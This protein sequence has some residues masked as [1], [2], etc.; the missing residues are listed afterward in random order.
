METLSST[1]EWDCSPVALR[2][3]LRSVFITPSVT[4]AENVLFQNIGVN[5]AGGNVTL[6]GG[7]NSFTS[8]AFIGTLTNTTPMNT[9]AESN[10]SIQAPLG[11][12]SLTGL[13]FG[14]T[15]GGNHALISN[16][17]NTT[18]NAANYDVAINVGNL[19]L[20]GTAPGVM[21]T[22]FASIFSSRNLDVHCTH[23]SD[24]ILTAGQGYATI[25]ANGIMTFDIDGNV[26]LFGGSGFSLPTGQY[27]CAQIGNSTYTANA[28]GD[29]IFQN[30]GGTCTLNGGSVLNAFARIG[31]GNPSSSNNITG[32]I[33][34]NHVGGDLALNGGSDTT[35]SDYAQLGHYGADTS[36][37][38]FPT[39]TGDVFVNGVD[40]AIELVSGIIGH[41]GGAPGAEVTFNG[42]IQVQGNTLS[43]LG[44]GTAS[45]GVATVGNATIGFDLAQ[46]SLVTSQQILVSTLHGI[47]LSGADA[48]TG[49]P[50]VSGEA[51]IGLRGNVRATVGKLAV[52]STEGDIV[53]VAGVPATVNPGGNG[54]IGYYNL[55][56]SGN[57]NIVISELVFTRQRGISPL[58]AVPMIR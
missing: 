54:V 8:A 43:M 19:L 52:S 23:G 40:G 42:Q 44:N 5:T 57:P 31:H 38:P 9:F 56:T 28:T 18:A 39:V 36:T 13:T 41:A 46:N 48:G 25:S 34:L 22:G 37:F 20:T 50:T 51:T 11:T 17:T 35:G 53:L 21:S 3:M 45:T 33:I 7:V 6:T 55:S 47:A 30:I 32:Q 27:S 4:S 24:L 1:Q 2:A 15:G 29:I 58:P 12:L 26:E 14:G 16:V 49:A 10:I